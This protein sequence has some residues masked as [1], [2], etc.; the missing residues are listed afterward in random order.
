MKR[1]LFFATI[2]MAMTFSTSCEK[3]GTSSLIGFWADSDGGATYSTSSFEFINR[4]TVIEYKGTMLRRYQS[5]YSGAKNHVTHPCNSSYIYSGDT[6]TWTYAYEDNKVIITNGT[7]LTLMDGK[8]Y[9]DGSSG[10][11]IKINGK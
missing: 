10:H 5:G 8:L 2:I 3:N 1:L 11:L 7:I 4:N 9:K 6:N